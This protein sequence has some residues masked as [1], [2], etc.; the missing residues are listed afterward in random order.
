LGLNPWDNRPL[1]VRQRPPPADCSCGLLLRPGFDKLHPGII[2]REFDMVAA[3]S[4]DRLGRSLQNPI[5]FLSKLKAKEVDLDLH[6]QSADTSTPAGRALFQMLGV[7]AE[8][9]RA[10][11]RGAA[12]GE[13]ATDD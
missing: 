11:V 10:S 7:F 6:Q 2:R 12:T 3:W 5:S 13:S 1:V 4:V 8:F 9:E